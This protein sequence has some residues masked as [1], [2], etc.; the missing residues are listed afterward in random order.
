MNATY[1]GATNTALPITTSCS[2]NRSM[3]KATGNLIGREGRAFMNAGLSGSTF[4]T[5]V[6]N[7]VRDPRWVSQMICGGVL[8]MKS[9]HETLK[10]VFLTHLLFLFPPST[11]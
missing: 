7:I 11:S 1:P 4:W 8:V 9:D 6:I 3:W 10:F 5:P 2:F